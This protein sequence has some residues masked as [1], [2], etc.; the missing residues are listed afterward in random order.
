MSDAH[1]LMRIAS[2]REVG[3]PRGREGD[4]EAGGGYSAARETAAVFDRS[5][6]GK[7][8]VA[9]GDRRTYLQAMLTNDVLALAPGSGCY[10][11]YLT[12]QGRMI[13][14]MSVLE[15]GDLVLLDLD[16]AVTTTVLQ[17]LDQF[18][19]SEDVKLGDLSEAFGK[20]TVVGPQ[21]ARVVAGV[22]SDPRQPGL[23][24]GELAAWTEF[25]NVRARFRGQ[26]ALAAASWDL[27]EAGFDLYVE[28][29]QVPELAAA[30]AATGA[31]SADSADWEVLRV[32]AGRLAF[33]S[34]M[35]GDTM[36]LETGIE[37]RAISFTKGCYPGQEIVIR[38]LHRGQDR[39]PRRIVGLR[40]AG[41]AVPNP[42]DLVRG[43]DRDAG[44]VTSAV[45]SPR[46]GGPIALAM[47]HC[48]FLAPGT[49]LSI[50][51]GD[52]TLP[53]TV[54]TLPFVIA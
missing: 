15:L 24:E 47:V 22:M 18:I 43:G 36:V 1:D 53:A 3:K 50:Q 19:F 51:R 41:D 4:M 31:V 39:I 28:R 54:V 25:R 46:V 32:E 33:G 5:R 40:I 52:R 37:N 16:P 11:A 20:L 7:I 34:D 10:A 49:E 27:G 29:P 8:A 23:G 6:R 44:R 45:W 2:R 48:D 21:S 42:G 17:K 14:D 38:I 35:D 13:A 9:G 30:L 26:M 12:P